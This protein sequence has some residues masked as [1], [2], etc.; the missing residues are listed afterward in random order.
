MKRVWIA[1]VACALAAP[2]VAAPKHARPLPQRLASVAQNGTTVTLHFENG[3]SLDVPSKNLRIR[4][5]SRQ[6]HQPHI[7]T[8]EQLSSMNASGPL[9]AIAIVQEGRAAH[10]VRVRVFANDAETRAFLQRAADRQAA[11]EARKSNQ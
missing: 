1:L 2:I 9:P 11:R 4:N 10:R 7:L 5:A 8:V 6:P 3:T